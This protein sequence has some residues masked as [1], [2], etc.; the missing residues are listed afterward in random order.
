MEPEA[1]MPGDR[2]TIKFSLVNTAT[3]PSVTVGG[4]EFDTDARVQSASLEGTDG[5]EVTTG[6]YRDSGVIGPGESVNLT[7][8]IIVSDNIKDGTYYLDLAVEGNSPALSNTWRVPVT[9]DSSSVRVIP[10]S[11]LDLENGAGTLE[12]D[13]ANIHPN[14]LS[15]VSVK[16]QAEGIEF[17]PSEYFI[18]SMDPDELFTIQFDANSADNKSFSPKDLT[19]IASYRNGANQH[20]N[21]LDTLQL[22]SVTV[23]EGSNLGIAVAIILL[24]A[25]AVGGYF[26]YRRRKNKE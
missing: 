10:S 16:L 26:L 21:V 23:N 17:S 13:V 2:G 25:I 15:S 7:Y 19:I 14:Q 3:S 8:S 20:S 1:F 5:I 24:A 12:F 4:E 6:V 9:V 11:S 18:G 22:R